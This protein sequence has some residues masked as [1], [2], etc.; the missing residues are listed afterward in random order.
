[1]PSSCDMAI[2]EPRPRGLYCPA[3]DFYVDPWSPVDRAV[4]THAHAD[5]ARPGSSSYLISSEG[6]AVFRLRLGE[7]ANL[8]TVAFG[9]RVSIGDAIVSLHPAGHMLGSA[10]VRVETAEGVCVVTG[11]YKRDG[12]NT[13]SPF[14]TVPCDVLVT[15]STFGLPVYRW[16]KPAAVA[17]EINSWWS[18]NREAGV[19]SV[20]Y[21]YAIGK[22]QRVLSILDSG[23]GPILTH[24][25]IESGTEAYR[26][27]G[28]KL[29][30]TIIA[31]G[32]TRDQRRGAMVLAV[33]GAD[34]TP[35]LRRFGTIST[36]MVSGWMRIRGVRRYRSVDRG[37]VMS[38]HVDW[39]A[40][41][42]TVSDTGA[43]RVLAT[44][45]YTGPVV[46]WFRD[47]GLNA[48]A[49][50]TRFSGEAESE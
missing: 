28:V 14:E 50:E 23:I 38:D 22:A 40:L 7:N 24:G 30:E 17:E 18:A 37:F 21:A 41:L 45:G 34:G 5:H 42:Q 39:P 1:M 47:Q 25:A 32:A 10:Q 15:E 35:W 43:S 2:L 27:A 6:E 26:E 31:T 13:C 36:A 48:D 4:V 29:P 44:H 20:L 12:D 49:L 11:D 8:Q 33:P 9:D 46:R 19:T 3:G 16:P